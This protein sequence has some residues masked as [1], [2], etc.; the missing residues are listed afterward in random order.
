MSISGL[1][2]RE[3]QILEILYRRGKA[4]AN[5]VHEEMPK[6]TYSAVRGML[7][8][9][10]EK[11]LAV[12]EADGVRYVYSPV[13]PRDEAAKSELRNVLDTFFGNSVEQVVVTLL[14]EHEN[15][16]SDATLDRLSALIEQA[17]QERK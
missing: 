4:T 3:R 16:L 15:D 8:V 17:K 11:G 6:M 5:D 10:S 13:V 1:S 2:K 12:H 14:S 7:R 9:L